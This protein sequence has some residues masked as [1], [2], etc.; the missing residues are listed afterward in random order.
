MKE[1][2]STLANTVGPSSSAET[3]YDV[4]IIGGGPAG[5]STAIYTVRAGLST[6]ILD[7]GTHNGALAMTTKIAN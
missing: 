4:L 7:K 1:A 6:L 5:T 3:T 2:Q